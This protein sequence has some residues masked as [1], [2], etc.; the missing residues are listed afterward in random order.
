MAKKKCLLIG[1][2]YPGTSHALRGCINDIQLWN[3]VLSQQ[4]GFVDAR[5][6]K[7]LTDRRAT[8]QEIIRALDWLTSDLEVGDTI[9]M[10]YSGHG[11]QM[12]DL[13]QDFDEEPDGKDE[14][15]CPVDLDW[16]KNVIKD[17]DFRDFFDRV[18]PGIN[19]TV[20]LDC[21]HSGQGLRSLDEDAITDLHMRDEL[22]GPTR[23]RYWPMPID[24]DIVSENLETK[25]RGLLNEQYAID[26]ENQSGILISGCQSHQTSADAWIQPE[27]KFHGA[28]TYYMIDILRKNQ[29]KMTYTDLIGEVNHVLPAMGFSQCPELNGQA[30]YFNQLF[31]A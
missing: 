19:V 4:F 14:I 21:C 7:I 17:D 6:K 31:L 1:I 24:L 10:A 30:K 15:I 5:Y 26:I 25:S 23:N 2:N 3:Q 18:K 9:F 22:F 20:V 27:R 16:K 28:L 13:E 8:T 12:I 11:S 29:W